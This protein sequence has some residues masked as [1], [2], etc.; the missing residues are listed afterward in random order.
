MHIWSC[1]I[2]K[3]SVVSVI[4]K[5]A[6]LMSLTKAKTNPCVPT[7]CELIELIDLIVLQAPRRPNPVYF[8]QRLST[9]VMTNIVQQKLVYR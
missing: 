2:S 6:V 7:C 3:L 8:Q 5:R 4:I 9:M 1:S